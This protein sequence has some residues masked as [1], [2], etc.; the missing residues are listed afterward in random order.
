MP[1]PGSQSRG[2]GTGSRK[3]ESNGL[4]VVGINVMAMYD[5]RYR[6][7]PDR[8]HYANDVREMA[9]FSSEL[10]RRGYPI[11]FFSTQYPDYD[12][13]YD[14]LAALDSDV[15]DR[16]D[17]KVIVRTVESVAGLMDLLADANIVVATRLH[18]TLMASLSNKPVVG[19]CYYRKAEELLKGMGQELYGVRFK[20][21]KAG[22][23]MDRFDRLEA[24]RY[25]EVV[26]ISEKS[27]QYRE[28]LEQYQHLTVAE[29]RRDHRPAQSS[30]PM[31]SRS[32]SQT[33]TSLRHHF[34]F[35]R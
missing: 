33:F 1:R 19:V 16:V 34:D 9:T 23:L 8:A 29:F 31:T 24:N 22:D 2:F 20:T 14:V 3:E 12:S 26:K 5:Q 18:G 21:F 4:A 28:A 27:R 11:F 15:L 30:A 17:L 35:G 6:W 10:I 7:R 25:T 13:I 32:A